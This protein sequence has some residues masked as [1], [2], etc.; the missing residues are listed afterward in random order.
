MIRC[1]GRQCIDKGGAVGGGGY[2]LKCKLPH[3]ASPHVLCGW[4]VDGW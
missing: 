3:E 2:I 4:W 1:C